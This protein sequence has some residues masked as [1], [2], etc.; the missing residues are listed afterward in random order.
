MRRIYSLAIATFLSVSC[1]AQ[2]VPDVGSATKAGAVAEAMNDTAHTA[3][4]P[5]VEDGPVKKNYVF[6]TMGATAVIVIVAITASRRRRN[7][8]NG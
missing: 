3:A 7:R 8:R 2:A 4:G 5:Q 6:I 1:L